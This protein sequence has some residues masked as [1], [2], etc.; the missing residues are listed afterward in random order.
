LLSP[1]FPDGKQQV[2][3]F[4]RDFTDKG[5]L[6]LD[7]RAGE[8]PDLRQRLAAGEVILSTTLA[9]RAGVAIGDDI[10]LQ[11]C[12]GVKKLTVAATA[13][14]YQAGGMIVYMEGETARRLLKADGVDLFSVNAQPGKLDAVG[15]SLAAWTNDKGLLFRSFADVLAQVDSMTRGLIAG[16]WG[17][18]VLGLIVGAF[19]IANT[20]TMNVLEQTRELALL[21]VVAMTRWQVRKSIL[22][23]ALTIGAIGILTGTVGGM[24]GAYVINLC[25]AQLLGHA[26]VFALHPSLLVACIGIGL[27]VIVAAAWIPAERAARLKLLIALQ[28]E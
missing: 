20:L 9:H 2:I 13:T 21:R 24:I 16:L 17:L 11:T 18:L 23:Q 14:A 8:T 25:Y 5:T 4:V 22:A 10:S 15:A 19:A 3:A 26:P 27:V 28:Y 12:D 7:I 6:P 1:K